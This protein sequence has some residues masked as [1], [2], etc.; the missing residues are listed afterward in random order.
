[1]DLSNRK[2]IQKAVKTVTNQSCQIDCKLKKQKSKFSQ[3]S[4]AIDNLT[5]KAQEIF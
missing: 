4:N 2:K 5:K 3:N 1:M